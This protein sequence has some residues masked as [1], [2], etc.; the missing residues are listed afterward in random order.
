MQVLTSSDTGKPKETVIVYG[1]ASNPGAILRQ[2]ATD[3]AAPPLTPYYARVS[4]AQPNIR[5]CSPGWLTIPLNLLPEL[6][7]PA[8]MRNNCRQKVI[9][10]ASQFAKLIRQFLDAY[11]DF[12]L[13]VAQ[14]QDTGRDG[15]L[16]TREDWF[17]SAWLPLPEARIPLPGANSEEAEFADVDIA[18]WVDGNLI[19]VTIE[20]SSTRRKS[21]QDRLDRLIDTHPAITYIPAPRDSFADGRFPVE[22][23]PETFA[24]F[25]HGLTLPHGPC[26]PEE[27]EH[28]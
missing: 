8:A 25:T 11:L 7:T 9:I 14:R 16:F 19:A 17:Y 10:N 23:F 18:Y 15:D 12:A 1:R 24:E 22:L 3:E 2:A 21:A 28:I 4:R 27:L 6:N 5:L 20:G 13:D 26:P